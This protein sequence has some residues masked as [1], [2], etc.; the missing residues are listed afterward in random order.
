M[1][2]EFQWTDELVAEFALQAKIVGHKEWVNPQL[3]KFKELHQP[4]E[5]VK[6]PEREEHTENVRL[7]IF[8]ICVESLINTNSLESISDTPDYISAEFIRKVFEIFNNAIRERNRWYKSDEKT[9][10]QEQVDKIEEEAFNAGR[11]R[12]VKE[13]NGETYYDYPTF[14]HYK[15]KK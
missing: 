8:E 15:N 13:Q 1:K 2:N 10:T 3:E 9:Y 7:D 5:E 4:K 11:G 14:K 6:E 12:Y